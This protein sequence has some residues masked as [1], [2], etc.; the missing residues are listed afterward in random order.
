MCIVNNIQKEMEMEMDISFTTTSCQ[1][2]YTIM[3][4]CLFVNTHQNELEVG[5]GVEPLSTTT[6]AL[7]TN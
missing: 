3:N 4:V 7:R 6:T 5:Y 2:A 1:Q